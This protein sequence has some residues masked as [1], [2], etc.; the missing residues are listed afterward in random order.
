MALEDMMKGECPSEILGE[1]GTKVAYY[2]DVEENNSQVSGIPAA[3]KCQIF[4]QLPE[5][6]K[7]FLFFQVYQR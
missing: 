4:E 2:N 3:L 7:M 1:E 6:L 5:L